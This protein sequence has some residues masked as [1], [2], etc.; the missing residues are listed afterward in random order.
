MRKIIYPLLAVCAVVVLLASAY[1]FSSEGGQSGRVLSGTATLEKAPQ[2]AAEKSTVN[3]AIYQDQAAE[4]IEQSQILGEFP[5]VNSRNRTLKRLNDLHDTLLA[6]KVPAAYLDFHLQLTALS[7]KIAMA[8]EQNRPEEYV[9]GQLKLEELAKE[10][11]S[12]FE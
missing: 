6:Q 10:H 9:A 11:P 3:Q 7:A 8:V 1:S 4:L 12:L 5:A 2:K